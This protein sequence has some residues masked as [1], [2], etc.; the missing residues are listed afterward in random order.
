MAAAL[1]HRA[2]QAENEPLKSIKV[3]SAGVAT[4]GGEKVTN[5]SVTAL[6]N[7]GIDISTHIS[8]PLTETLMNGALAIV[9][10]TPSHIASVKYKLL[11]YAKNNNKETL[12]QEKNNNTERHAN[13]ECKDPK[14]SEID[15]ATVSPAL[16]LFRQFAGQ[17][18]TEI[19]DP[20]G[21]SLEDY[22]FC[23]DSMIQAIPSLIE[24]IK[25][26]IKQN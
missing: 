25:T 10:M 15:H 8:Q 4:K 26:Q 12:N 24:F 18:S 20:Y 9:C 5:H 13:T 6:Q 3:V 21:S 17:N 7:I 11:V 2:L 23:R 22:M 1:L 14:D 19:P 16:V